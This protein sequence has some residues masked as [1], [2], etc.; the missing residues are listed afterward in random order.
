MAGR[1]NW[2]PGVAGDVGAQVPLDIDLRNIIERT[3]EYVLRNGPEFERMTMEKNAENPAFGFLFPSHPYYPY[4][5]SVIA[6]AN[7]GV[8]PPAPPGVHMNMMGTGSG[9][10]MVP[11]YQYGQ[12]PPTFPPP[13]YSGAPAPAVPPPVNAAL[14]ASGLPARTMHADRYPPRAYED[15]APAAELSEVDQVGNLFDRIPMGIV[16]D[17][18]KKTPEGEREPYGAINHKILL[19][20]GFP[21]NSCA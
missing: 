4:Y 11:P 18:Y 7:A 16:V 12:H 19:S 8:Y 13:Q 17:H 10:S 20:V 15:D 6:K 3:A 1:E 14:L 5:Q 9:S 2:I 21:F